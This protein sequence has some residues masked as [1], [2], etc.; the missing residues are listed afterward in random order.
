MPI[1]NIH[2]IPEDRLAAVSLPP[3]A[4]PPTR[5]ADEEGG[6]K[7]GEGEYSSRGGRLARERVAKDSKA[8]TGNARARV[9]KGLKAVT[10]DAGARSVNGDA[11]N[12]GASPQGY[13]SPNRRDPTSLQMAQVGP[14]DR[15][16][17]GA[18][19][20]A[21]PYWRRCIG[22][23]C[24]G[25]LCGSKPLLDY[26][27]I[28]R[29]LEGLCAVYAPSHLRPA[30]TRRAEAGKEAAA[31]SV[32]MQPYP[33]PRDRAVSRCR[34]ASHRGRA[35]SAPPSTFLP[36]MLAT[37]HHAAPIPSAASSA[38]TTVA[39]CRLG[40]EGDALSFQTNPPLK[41]SSSLPLLSLLALEKHITYLDLPAP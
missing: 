38:R 19:D 18:G 34:D 1:R 14:R 35:A 17:C 31:A 8:A 27:P 16:E 9:G 3:V 40:G 41:L 12:G 7:G 26:S 37:P 5:E 33:H 22:G 11:G 29:T 15:G 20:R 2:R 24:G 39:A 23:R 30:T 21:Q 6:T 28:L 36:N 13:Q 32:M 4:N 25:R 10:G